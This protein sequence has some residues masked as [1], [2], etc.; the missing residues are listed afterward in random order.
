[1]RNCIPAAG[2]T[3][4]LYALLICP[5]PSH[6]AKLTA[7]SG[8]L[9]ARVATTIEPCLRSIA[10]VASA[11]R[12]RAVYAPQGVNAHLPR[13]IRVLSCQRV[14]SGFSAR[15]RCGDRTY[16]YYLPASVLGLSPAGN[17]R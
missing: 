2:C 10:E 9:A 6:V 15:E 14:N 1:M 12:T 3:C 5:S 13:D 11:S 16:H 8:V 4:P 7:W 17:P